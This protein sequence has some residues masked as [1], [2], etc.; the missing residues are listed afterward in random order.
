MSKEREPSKEIK[1]G[2][3]GKGRKGG[4]SRDRED[5]YGRGRDRA[6]V[7]ARGTFLT[8]DCKGRKIKIFSNLSILSFLYTATGRSG[9]EANS[10]K[11]YPLDLRFLEAGI[12]AGIS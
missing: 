5:Y 7:I 4:N 10:S 9:N 3:E 2:D 6:R 11:D 8:P 1:E 12:L